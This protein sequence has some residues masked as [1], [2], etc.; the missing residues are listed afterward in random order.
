MTGQPEAAA[1]NPEDE[2]ELVS[3]FPPPPYYYTQ[4]SASASTPAS[5]HTS[6][7]ASASEPTPISTSALT[8]PPIP[9]D[10]LIRSTKKAAALAKKKDLEEKARLGGVEGMGL[11]MGMGMGM[12]MGLG[13]DGAGMLDGG[14]Q[15]MDTDQG[16]TVAV[17]GDE[18]YVEV[19]L[20][21]CLCLR[22]H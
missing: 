1:Q 6:G 16:P 20:C 22:S 19:G 15:I 13:M 9:H 2:A 3:E 12:G 10:A 21:I 11:G 18:S 14:T 8:P 4:A 7:Q 5:A 17:F